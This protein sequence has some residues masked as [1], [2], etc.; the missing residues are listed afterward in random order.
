MHNALRTRKEKDVYYN[1]KHTN[2]PI[3]RNIYHNLSSGR[4]CVLR[5]ETE[6][7]V[8]FNRRVQFFDEK[9]A[10]DPFLFEENGVYTVIYAVENRVDYRQSFDLIRFT[11]A[12]TLQVNPYAEAAS[13]SP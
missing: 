2:S 11:E 6:D 12:C 5:K 1:G 3:K 7:F 13:E 10:R 9:T 4:R 8:S